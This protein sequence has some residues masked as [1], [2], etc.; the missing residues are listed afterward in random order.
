MLA[1][2]TTEALSVLDQ[3]TLKK[4]PSSIPSCLPLISPP[5]ATSWALDNR[6]LFIASERTIH[7]YDPESNSLV[8]LFSS[9]EN[10][11][12]LVV[13]DRASAVFS[14]SNKVHILEYGET[15]KISQTFTTHKATVNSLAISSD[16]TLL[17]STSADTVYIHNLTLASHTALRGLP[18]S[19][20]Q[21]IRTCSFHPHSRTRLLLGIGRQLIIYDTSRPSGP[22][23]IISLKE[24]S[25]GSIDAISCSPF[26]KT[27][28]AVATTGG[29]LGLVDLDKEKG[30]TY[31]PV[32]VFN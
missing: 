28:V 5:I 7:R 21:S 18:I 3:A 24:A 29:T 22:T 32:L 10:L 1:I 30:Y 8:D 19:D 12:S 23:K 25:S 31:V 26:S 16:L 14:A 20:Q 15:S 9:P 11:S 6:F 2:T 27:L 17:A 4:T 13:K